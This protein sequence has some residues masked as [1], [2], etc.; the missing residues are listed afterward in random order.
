ML[1]RE[2]FNIGATVL[3]GAYRAVA[4]FAVTFFLAD[5]QANKFTEQYFW[6]GLVGSITGVPLAALCFSKVY[7]PSVYKFSLFLFILCLLLSWVMY[8]FG[9][10]FSI[11][12][13]FLFFFA[14]IL[15]GFF[16]IYRTRLA[17]EGAFDKIFY[18][19]IVSCLLACVAIPALE[20]FPGY[21][22]V[23]FVFP[24]AL[25]LFFI[26]VTKSVVTNVEYSWKKL[27]HRFTPVMFSSALSTGFMFLLPI[28]LISE[29][30]SNLAATL[31]KIFVISNIA[32]I[33]PR[34]LSS[35]LVP[36]IR[37]GKLSY[38]GL[39]RS[40]KVI[41]AYC[42]VLSVFFALILWCFYPDI[43]Y[44]SFLFFAIQTSQLTLPF[45]NVLMTFNCEKKIFL[46]NLMSTMVFVVL[47]GLTVLF[48]EA[49][50]FRGVIICVI[51]AISNIYR[52][53]LS[54]M[55]TKE[56]MGIRV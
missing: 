54:L 25:P 41:T 45:S 16:E 8:L 52:M 1:P 34:V 44:F 6:L 35:R 9:N 28:L 51:Y 53:R 43:L 48:F 13:Q 46:I 23:F 32:F 27:F 3:P 19:I 15:V 18:A 29:F 2:L 22:L 21:A 56:L 31:G 40:Y 39:M 55:K 17:V 47:A 49:G 7:K 5:D 4:F 50:D 30:G 38:V 24:L 33:I 14:T 20:F 10:I 26:S 12:D 42:S 11:K 37:N 36:Q